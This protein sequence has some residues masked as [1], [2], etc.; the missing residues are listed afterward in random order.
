MLVN[1]QTLIISPHIAAR[2]LSSKC[3]T[4]KPFLHVMIALDLPVIMILCLACQQGR[5]AGQSKL[6]KQMSNTA[7]VLHAVYTAA[8]TTMMSMT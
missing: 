7:F 6:A 1:S 4:A 5:S 3:N 8:H 2:M